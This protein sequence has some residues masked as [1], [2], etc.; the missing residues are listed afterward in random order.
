MAAGIHALGRR[1]LDG[2][3]VRAIA[4]DM[5]M[6]HTTLCRQ[7]REAG[8]RVNEK[9][10]RYYRPSGYVHQTYHNEAAARA[11]AESAEA[12]WAALKVRFEDAPKVKDQPGR[13]PMVGTHVPQ[14]S[15]IDFA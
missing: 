2:E 3:S 14:S 8:Y 15:S 4:R 12:L 7:L 11:Q 1:Y 13:L 9:G 6:P 5:H 10:A